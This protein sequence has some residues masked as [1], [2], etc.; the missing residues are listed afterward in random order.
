MKKITLLLVSGISALTCFSQVPD[1][2]INFDNS[3]ITYTLVDFGGNS[4]KVTT[5]PVSS[6]NNVAEV[7]K[8]N[9]AQTWA[10]T[11]IGPATG[12]A[13]KIPFSSTNYKITMK[14]YSPDNGIVVRL[15]AEDPNDPTKS[16]ETD[17]KTTKTND[18][19]TLE[20][21][22]SKQAT[23]TAAI[24]YSYTYQ[25]LSVFFNFGVDGATAGTK[26]YYCDDIQMTA[27]TKA[28]IDLPVSFEGS[29]VDYTMT[30]F[31][32]NVSTVVVDPTSSTNSVAQVDK[33]NTAELW[34]GTTIGTA[35]GFANKI[36]FTANTP[37]MTVR[38]WSPDSGIVIRLKAE[39]AGNGSISVETD[40]LTTQKNTWET[41]EFDF[42]KQVSGTA[43]INYSNTY[44]KLSI[45]F[46]FGVT[47]ATAGAKTYY[48]DDVKMAPAINAQ[49]DLPVTFDGTKVDYTMIDFGGTTSAVV[50]DPTD[51]SNKVAEVLKSNTAEL[52]AGTTIGTNDG[53][54]KKIPFSANTPK[55]TMRVWSPDSGIVVRLKAE[56]PANPTI[57]V[58]TDAI[59]FKKNDWQTLEFDFSKQATGTAA[60]NYSNTYQKLSVFFNF[61][62]TGAAAGAK[63]YYFDDVEMGSA[64]FKQ[65]DL[66]VTFDASDVDY[67]MIDFGGNISAIVADPMTASNKVGKVEKTATAELWAGTTIGTTDGFANA[68]PFDAT[69]NTITVKVYSPDAGIVVKLKAEDINDPSKS[70]E[71]DVTTKVANQWELLRFD[72]TKNSNGT[73]AI[74]YNTTYKKLSIFFNFGVTGATAGSKT[75]YFDS[76]AMGGSSTPSKVNVTFQVDARNVTL[77]TGEVLTLNGSF[78]NW[79]GACAPMTKTAGSDVWTLT[80]PL[81]TATEYEYKFVVGNWVKDEKLAVGL[82]CVKTTGQF[83][84][85]VFRTG[86]DADTLPEVCWESCQACGASNVTEQMS[87]ALRVFPNPAS[88]QVMVQLDA[89]AAEGANISVWNSLGQEVLS[90]RF[91][92]GQRE[93]QL[94]VSSLRTGIYLIK[95]QGNGTSWSQKIQVQ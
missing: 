55:L 74:N 83:T 48:F 11:T 41:L 77:G 91:A 4:S 71:T 57:S 18:W 30:D 24:N 26:V 42:T 61:G 80:V 36:P 50:T 82:P 10:G 52:W 59:T 51:A 92:A 45:F 79:C 29:S 37:K 95:I 38:V 76:V 20:F 22:F 93:T 73:P 90:G 31:G 13:N 34:A 78:N 5:D 25:K 2:P 16:V 27:A 12:L 33:G 49:I 54:A 64:L 72:F 21:D 44:D 1:L 8:T 15:K 62:V 86:Y 32:G 75:Y 65:I 56:D 17:A 35:A 84:N 81:D 14:V 46:N 60:I 89:A 70:V 53:F 47:G 87:S 67:T 88:S 23:G 85:R 28:Q 9:T 63:T 6:S 58:E 69:H 39:N 7:T 3:S 43:A 40:A 19:E 68:I 66:P 94:D